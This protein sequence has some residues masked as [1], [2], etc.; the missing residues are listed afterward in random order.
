M[1]STPSAEMKD[2]PSSYT[3]SQAAEMLGVSQHVIREMVNRKEL[4]DVSPAA[5]TGMTLA[6]KA[7]RHY[8]AVSK[9]SLDAYR[10]KVK[11]FN[12]AISGNGDSAHK[13]APVPAWEA[14][15]AQRLPLVDIDMA[16]P[17]VPPPPVATA[18]DQ[19][20]EPRTPTFPP[21]MRLMAHETR[22]D[23][24]DSRIAAL[25]AQLASL[26]GQWQ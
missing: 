11:A 5:G 4:E 1:K 25:E 21:L 17:P 3:T 22:I 13:P 10:A 26:I 24:H 6:G 18:P 8:K 15:A 20:P 2:M 14:P 7:G 19:A 9:A 12:A 23:A 16:P